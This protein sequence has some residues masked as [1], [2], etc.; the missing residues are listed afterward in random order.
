MGGLFAPPILNRVNFDLI[1]TAFFTFLVKTDYFGQGNVIEFFDKFSKKL[2][3]LRY[4]NLLFIRRFIKSSIDLQVVIN[5]WS[6]SCRVRY[7]VCNI[8]VKLMTNSDTGVII[9]RIII[10]KV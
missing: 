2:Q 6:T 8:T 7:V 10:G 9:I 3:K 1:I 5:V 4:F